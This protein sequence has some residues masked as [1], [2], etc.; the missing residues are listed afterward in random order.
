MI[1]EDMTP[2]STQS[3]RQTINWLKNLDDISSFSFKKL[4]ESHRSNIR[5]KFEQHRIVEVQK[6]FEKLVMAKTNEDRQVA[7]ESLV[8]L[9]QLA[10][11][12][13]ETQQGE[14]FENEHEEQESYADVSV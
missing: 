4:D 1:L 14:E 13:D 3:I 6:L 8:Y 10:N 2:G 5:N 12:Q 7:F 11:E 9:L